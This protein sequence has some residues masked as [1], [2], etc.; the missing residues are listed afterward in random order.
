MTVKCLICDKDAPYFTESYDHA[1]IFGREGSK[2]FTIWLCPEHHRQ[3][4]ISMRNKIIRMRWNRNS[5]DG[6]GI[7]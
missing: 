5:N 6:M 7:E 2:H 4:L 1:D 3:F